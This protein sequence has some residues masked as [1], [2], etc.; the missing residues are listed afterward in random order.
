MAN[1]SSIGYFGNAV[2]FDTSTDYEKFIKFAFFTVGIV[3][4]GYEN[5][6]K[7]IQSCN[8]VC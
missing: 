5:R 4:V 8:E 6:I 1:K 3:V 2:C 7:F